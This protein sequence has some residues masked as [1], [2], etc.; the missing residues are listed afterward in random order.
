[1]TQ[2]L[3][4]PTHPDRAE[5]GIA[6][7]ERAVRAELSQRLRVSDRAVAGRMGNAVTV[8]DFPLVMQAYA[9]GRIAAG[10]VWAMTRAAEL[11]LTG[12]PSTTSTGHMPAGWSA[13]VTAEVQV[14]VPALTLL[15][16]DLRDR[17]RQVPELQEL[18]GVGM[19]AE[20]PGYGPISD[21][22]ARMFA[23]EATGWDAVVVHPQ[24][25]SVLTV[26]YRWEVTQDDDGIL[27]WR[28]PLGAE[29]RDDP[30]TG[31]IFQPVSGSFGLGSGHRGAHN[32][33]DESESSPPF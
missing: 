20:M 4:K 26:A 14:I 6:I 32:D 2:K 3:G 5:R 16:K 10:H 25:A 28:S 22:V 15:P 8:T 11:L 27:T 30:E 33:D 1:M 19:P 17:L 24:R 21:E 9:A 13:R 31:V 23:L 12:E 7:A 18:A 29:F